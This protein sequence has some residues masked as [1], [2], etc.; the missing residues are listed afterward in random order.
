MRRTIMPPDTA[1]TD[2]ST[3]GQCYGAAA[4]AQGG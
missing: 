2:T 3:E 4:L 1:N